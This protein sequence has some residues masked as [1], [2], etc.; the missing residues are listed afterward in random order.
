MGGL[1]SLPPAFA[2]VAI[3][4]AAGCGSSGD[5]RRAAPAGPAPR[6]IEC[7][8]RLPAPSPL[9]GVRPEQRTA[10][11]WLERAA[12]Q[13]GLD[14]VLL[15]AEEI[16][17]HDQALKAPREDGKSLGWVDLTL[18]VQ[19]AA[20]RDELAERLG[21]LRERAASGEYVDASGR[22]LDAARVEV[23]AVPDPLPEIGLELH[24][25]LANV[26]FR[27]G[28]VREGLYRL[29]VDAAFNR[30]SCGSVHP[31]EPV[32]V[33]AR[34]PG[35]SMLARAR[36]SFGWIDGVA[37]LSPPI[38]G[39][40]A[41]SI[42]SGPRSELL[43]DATLEPEEGGST[44]ALP[45]GTLLASVR[46]R[47]GRVYFASATGM[48]TSQELPATV[49]RSTERP[50]TRRAV[51]EAAFALVDSPYGWGGDRGGRDCSGFLLDVFASFG[52]QLPR[53]SARQALAG[54]GSL[55]VGPE[56]GEAER[57]ALLDEAGR[58]GVVLLHFPG[59]IMLYLGRAEDGAP[60]AIHSFA[61][62]LEPCAGGGETLRTVD[63][64]TVSDLSLGRGTSRRSFLERITRIVILG[65]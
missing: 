31:Q 46:G 36:H 49:L 11:Y 15:S 64:V 43:A 53:D 54:T 22:R 13:G 62:Y 6:A 42:A 38:R 50:L 41:A 24:L 17:L 18:P 1:S 34:W 8:P 19:T 29:P 56:E 40:V 25:T 14:D 65:H 60:M 32:L 59:H 37:P 47:S 61:E 16:A 12:L 4:G 55:P 7:P 57:L 63:R 35:G 2:L 44:S 23:F 27:C 39:P 21:Y 45:R 30:N 48:H 10:A 5:G 28:P 52:L 51:L 20:L 3:V 58:R 26:Q 9:P 33:L